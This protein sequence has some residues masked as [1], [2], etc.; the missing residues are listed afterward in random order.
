MNIHEFEL[1]YRAFKGLSHKFKLNLEQDTL[2]NLVKIS[3]QW[4]LVKEL[5]ETS[6]NELREL[7]LQ[8]Y[9]NFK[10]TFIEK[11]R[12]HK[13]SERFTLQDYLERLEYELKV[14]K[15]MGFKSYF[16]IVSDF[17]RRA[18]KN[19]IVVGPGRG[20]GAGSILAWL[21]R[22]TDIDPLPY[23]LIF[24]RFLNPARISMPDFDIDFEDTQREKV[25][26]YVEDKYGHKNVCS[27]WTFM[28]L[29]TKAAFKDAAR[30]IGVDFEKSNKFSSLL[31]DRTSI[32]EALNAEGNAELKGLY[33]S[34]EK[35]QKAVQFGI[36]L[37][38][39][40]RQLGMHACGVIIAP[41]EVIKYT[42]TQYVK[43]NDH[44]IV[45][46]YDGPNLE[47]IG[48]LKMDFLGLRNLSVIK[49]CIKIIKKRCEKEKTELPKIFESF[50]VD[51]SFHPPLDDQVT[52][53]KVFQTG[54]TT[55]IFQFEST[56]MKKNLID[57]QSNSINDLVAMNALYRP[58][59]MEFIP[60]YI[61]RK[62][63]KEEIIYMQPELREILM[64]K[65]GEQVTDEENMK[66]IEDLSSIMNLTYGIAV[67]QEQLMLLSQSMAGFSLSE[68]DNLR[69]AVGK[70]KKDL[71]EKI[72][73]EF[74]ARCEEYRKYTPE[75]ATFIYEKVIEPAGSYSFNKSH[76]V[77]YSYIAYQTAYLKAHY[78]T[79][80]Y[81]A[82]IRSVEEDTDE[83]SKYI[84][85]TQA[86]GVPI[87]APDINESF[88][89]VAALGDSIRLGFFCIKWVGIDI[90]EYIQEE[91]K[92][93]G[94]Y[95]SLEN[96]LKR[97]QQV[98][99]KKSLEWLTK[100]GALDAF[101]DR[102]TILENTENI[103]E[104]TK[105]A[106]QSNQ[107]LFWG[108][109]IASSINFKNQTT[110]TS[111]E[112]LMM[113]QEVFKIFVS[114]NPLDGLYPYL[115]KRSFLSQ[116][117]MEDFAW[118]FII[119][120]YISNIQ[121]AKKKG[122]FIEVED[123]SAKKEF[124]VKEILDFKKNDILIIH[125]FKNKGGRMPTLD[126]IVKINL[127]TLR[128][129]AGSK[130]DP[131]MTVVKVKGLRKKEITKRSELAP[132]LQPEVNNPLSEG[133]GFGVR[134][135][136]I[137]FKTPESITKIQLLSQIIK[138]YPG[139]IKIYIGTKEIQVN[140]EW[141]GKIADIITE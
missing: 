140:E 55:G 101:Q 19:G 27:I 13:I 67:Y 31:P 48:L 32:T 8:T 69:K 83:L 138:E 9:T 44:N 11:A 102:K 53:E 26:R 119:T 97:C 110:T 45:S 25:I 100:A 1:R 74:V 106:G 59:P 24:E 57:L 23:D 4:N 71:I 92:K 14:I 77:C 129:K 35:V 5:T 60:N 58:W 130:Y 47:T 131:E 28:Q 3:D 125:G 124:F 112:K 42:P 40:L 73:K 16:L 72:K 33:N 80:F 122:F 93:G 121:R 68:A 105:G 136:S 51:T 63:G 61:K 103:L 38:G 90:G 2:I 128:K 34:D 10:K 20:S 139:N 118:P 66:L 17:V 49:N 117:N 82:L 81:A 96:F 46:Q 15:E 111:M 37:E 132:E 7:T 115:K 18:K 30:V 137:R 54:E 108:D 43:E 113:E 21:T 56:G 134:E 78:P 126:K 22:I 12:E 104:R 85:E 65:Y 116:V 87:F 91:R 64:K 133:E 88:N 79:E 50:F 107:W 41:E 89:H 62:H 123:I 114:G 70:K 75:T 52:F 94:K 135:Q 120:G 76:S 36:Q 86:Q 29:A 99:N 39:N 141:L 109:S 127:E 98:I 6:P 95:T 84:Y